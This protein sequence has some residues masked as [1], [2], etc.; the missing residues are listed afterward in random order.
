[1][2]FLLEVYHNMFRIFKYPLK[3]IDKQIIEITGCQQI[4]SVINQNEQLTLYVL[5][6]DDAKN[7]SKLK[8][9]I[10]GTGHPIDNLL[11]MGYFV[12]TISTYH[13][14]LIWHVFIKMIEV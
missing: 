11:E 4:L 1:M 14:S 10:K 9:T 13:G 8:V 6:K 3:I 5:I 7:T 2:H 12:G